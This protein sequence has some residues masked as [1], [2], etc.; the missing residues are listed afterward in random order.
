MLVLLFAFGFVVLGDFLAIQGFE[1][2][3]SCL[4]GTLPLE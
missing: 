1:L 4:L 3:A 2:K